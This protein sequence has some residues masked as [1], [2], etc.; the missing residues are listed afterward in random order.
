MGS[1]PGFR[2][3]LHSNPLMEEHV[4]KSAAVLLL[5]GG[6]FLWPYSASAHYDSLNG[7]V[8]AAAREAPAK[9]D[10]VPVLRWIKPENQGAVRE[11]F[12]KALAVRADAQEEAYVLFAFSVER[13]FSVAEA[14]RGH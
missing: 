3:L 14:T 1:V 8:V 5:L 6:P 7:P 11:V 9:G 4:M 13:I 12:N 2:V 10:V